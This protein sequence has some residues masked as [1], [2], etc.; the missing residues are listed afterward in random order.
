[1]TDRHRNITQGMCLNIFYDRA[2]TL[3]G[4]QG[5]F[6]VVND[7]AQTN[8]NKEISEKMC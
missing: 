3:G 4:I 2:A 7:M 1:M 6:F 5:M 8:D